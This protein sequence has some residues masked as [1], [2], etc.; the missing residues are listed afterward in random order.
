M[1]A[2]N[3]GKKVNYKILPKKETRSYIPEVIV[4]VLILFAFFSLLLIILQ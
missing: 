1:G 4:G 2:M 3:K